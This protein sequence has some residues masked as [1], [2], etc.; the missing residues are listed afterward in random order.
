MPTVSVVVPVHNA[1]EHFHRCLNSL[2]QADPPPDEII[3]VADGDNDDCWQ[4][5]ESLATRVIRLPATGG[6]ARARNHGARA[7][8]SPHYSW[9]LKFG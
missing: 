5:A 8:T 7:A 6:P 9:F 4:L 2:S 3:V 1:R